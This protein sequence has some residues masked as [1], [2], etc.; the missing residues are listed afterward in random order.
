MRLIWIGQPTEEFL[1][2]RGIRQ[3][4]P[5]SPY[6]FVLCMERLAQLITVEVQKKAWKPLTV[7][8]KA[9]KLSHLFFVDDLVLFAKVSL[10]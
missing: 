6:I 5:F 10:V 4:D 1:L 2:S 7:A 9:P 8:K 3:G